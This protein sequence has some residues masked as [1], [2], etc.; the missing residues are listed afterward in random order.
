M[1]ESAAIRDTKRNHCIGKLMPLDAMWLAGDPSAYT[2]TRVLLPCHFMSGPYFPIICRNILGIH[3]LRQV[4][5]ASAYLCLAAA[6]QAAEF[7]AKPIELIVPF[8]AGGGSDVFVRLFQKAIADEKLSPQPLVVRNLGG[9]GGTIGSRIARDA[10]PDGPP[11][12]PAHFAD[13]VD[14]SARN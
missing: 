2:H 5:R 13:A 1:P 12:L 10:K 3:P 14:L 4:F 7:P 6:A 8:N 9:A 11:P